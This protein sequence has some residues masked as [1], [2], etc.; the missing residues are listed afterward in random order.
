MSQQQSTDASA[1]CDTTTR[2]ESAKKEKKLQNFIFDSFS[3]KKKEKSA[4]A[5]DYKI[6][7]LWH[8]RKYKSFRFITTSNARTSTKR[9]SCHRTEIIMTL[10]A[11]SELSWSGCCQARAANQPFGTIRHYDS[12]KRIRRCVPINCCKLYGIQYQV[13]G[14]G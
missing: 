10:P 9:S 4:G 14:V 13:N 1:K 12:F 11:S 2:N 6:C 3:Q 5:Q 7:N 8:N